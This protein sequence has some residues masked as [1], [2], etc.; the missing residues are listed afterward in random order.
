MALAGYTSRLSLSGAAVSSSGNACTSLGGGVYQVTSTSRRIWDP[1]VTI[2]VRDG[3][4]A[5]PAANWAF[6]FLFGKVTFSGYTPSGAVTM[7]GSYLPTSVVAECKAH[8]I[9]CKATLADDTSYDSGGWTTKKVTL[10][11]ASGSFDFR[12]NPLALVSDA[13]VHSMLLARTV[14]VLELRFGS[15]WTARAF[16]ILSGVEVKAEAAGLVEG[17][18][19]FETAPQMAGAALAFES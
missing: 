6:D 18:A 3:G 9:S 17:T 16:A 8:G 15:T 12:S 13:S 2:T 19:N 7:D 5:V 14:K 11:G 10:L 4:T 1:S